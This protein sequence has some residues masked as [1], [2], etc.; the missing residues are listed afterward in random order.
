MLKAYYALTKPGIIYGNLLTAIAGYLFAS[1]WHIDILTFVGLALG[2]SLVIASAC[3]YNN[4]IDRNIDKFMKRT[5][6][7]ALVRGVI[8]PKAA[9]IYAACL[10]L[11]GL[12]LLVV[13]TNWLVVLVGVVAF[14]DYIVFYGY[15][16]RHS[17]Y[18]TLVGSV[19]GSASIVAGYVAVTNHFDFNA[20]CLFLILTL[21]Q[22]PHFYAIAIYR[23][24]DYAAAGLPVL[25]VKK[26]V[27][28]AQR[29]IMIY[30]VLLAATAIVF[31][32]A[33]TASYIAMQLLA[34]ISLAWFFYGL[35]TFKTEDPVAWARRMFFFSLIVNL[36]ISVT[37][38]FGTIIP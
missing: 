23:R 26:T 24:T 20:L 15:T 32:I 19:S 31:A 25:P 29:Q 2:T 16:K 36:A 22:M 14:V 18:S 9:L 17:V 12:T 10:G 28:I 8:S 34:G 33:G 6:E 35:N 3:V 4:Y 38:A 7:R 5:R 1:R 27:R 30:I 21:W 11:V 37:V 13:L